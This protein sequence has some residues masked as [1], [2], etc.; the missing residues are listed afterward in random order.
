MRRKRKLSAVAGGRIRRRR[1]AWNISRKMLPTRSVV[2]IDALSDA[3]AS[4]VA[5]RTVMPERSSDRL[6]RPVTATAPPA[7]ISCRPAAR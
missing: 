6:V 1:D 3:K 4:G 7:R 5:W 2:V